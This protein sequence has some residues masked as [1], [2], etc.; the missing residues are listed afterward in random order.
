MLIFQERDFMKNL[1]AILSLCFLCVGLCACDNETRQEKTDVGNVVKQEETFIPDEQAEMLCNE[2]FEC[3]LHEDAEQLES[4][5][6]ISV[7]KDYELAVEIQEAFEFVEG[8]IVSNDEPRGT[9]QGKKMQGVEGTVELYLEGIV[10]HVNTDEG[11]EY[12]ISFSACAVN[13]EDISQVGVTSIGIVN[14][15]IRRE[16]DYEAEGLQYRIGKK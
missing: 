14:E 16:G 9:V 13:K 8:T 10:L 3:F 2:I 6:S 5:F 11:N 15:E 12:R 1:V 4:M 7:Q